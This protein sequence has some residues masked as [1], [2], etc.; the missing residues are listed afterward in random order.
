MAEKDGT[1]C[2]EFDLIDHFIARHALNLDVAERAMNTS[3]RDTVIYLQLH[4]TTICMSSS[5]KS[6]T[7]CRDPL[8]S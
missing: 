6:T 3:S 2:E 8:T 1:R 7:G 5:R 4:A